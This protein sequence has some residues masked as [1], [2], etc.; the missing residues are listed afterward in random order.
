MI[1]DVE[2]LKSLPLFIQEYREIR[3]IMKAEN[4]D[5]QSY[6]DETEIILN[7]Q[8]IQSC[9]ETGISRFEKMMGITSSE[10]ESLQGR[11]SK[12]LS[13]WNDSIPYTFILLCRKLNALCGQ[14][15]Y[16]ITRNIN[17]Y[18]MEILTHLEYLGQVE[19]LEYLTSYMIP[20]NIDYKLNNK[21]SINVDGD[22]KPAVGVVFCE[23]I[24]ISD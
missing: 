1:R 8:F 20:A 3:E 12:V 4:P 10:D 24:E 21:I 18:T 2:L 9:N 17:E 5:F 11:I 7:N 6:S 14:N 22:I 13:R 19:E 23:L 15:N 16:E